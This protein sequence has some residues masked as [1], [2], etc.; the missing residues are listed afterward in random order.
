MHAS[1]A[2]PLEIDFKH[3]NLQS[4][5]GVQASEWIWKRPCHEHAWIPHRLH[6]YFRTLKQTSKLQTQIQACVWPILHNE[7]APTDPQTREKVWICSRTLRQEMEE[8]SPEIAMRWL[9]GDFTGN[10][11]LCHFFDISLPCVLSSF[12]FSWFLLSTDECKE[13]IQEWEAK[14]WEWLRFESC[15]F[16]RNRRVK[17][18]G[19]IPKLN[20][21]GKCDA[22]IG[23]KICY[24]IHMK[25]ILKCRLRLEM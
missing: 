10:A 5:I 21:R 3:F 25:L 12:L 11:L 2:W 18:H 7:V 15:E 4:S 8:Y 23:S 14:I 24:Q 17:N 6:S 22:F 19:E 16:V 9:S 1:E 13:K 20:W